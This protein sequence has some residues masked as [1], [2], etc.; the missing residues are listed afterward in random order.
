L[1]STRTKSCWQNDSAF[2]L[3]S[4]GVFALIISS[5][6]EDDT[7]IVS[8]LTLYSLV[9]CFLYRC[10]DAEVVTTTSLLLNRFVGSGNDQVL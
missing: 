9:I 1:F 7:L 4:S 5:F 8:S 6:G 2:S 3:A 10:S